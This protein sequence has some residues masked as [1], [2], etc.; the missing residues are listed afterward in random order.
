[1]A[2]SANV[3]IVRIIVWLA[4]GTW[5][6]CVDAARTLEGDVT[7]LYVV[8]VDTVAAM[9]G[10]VGLL[11]RGAPPSG[12]QM[13]SEAGEALLAAAEDRL[14]RDAEMVMRWGRPEREVVEVA[15]QGDLLVVARDGDRHRPGPRSL[16]HATRFVVDHAPAAVLLVWPE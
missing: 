7:L 9:S 10:Q 6:A 15:S 4:D 11:G 12:G 14:G 3:A 13:L 8:D 16:G 5:E 2:Q 1:M